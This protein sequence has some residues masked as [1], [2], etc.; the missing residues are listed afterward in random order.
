[1]GHFGE[2]RPERMTCSQLCSH[3]EVSAVHGLIQF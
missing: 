3:S 2:W 1:M